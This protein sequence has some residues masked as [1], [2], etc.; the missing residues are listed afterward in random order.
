MNR[1]IAGLETLMTLPG[2]GIPELLFMVPLAI[3]ILTFWIVVVA[4]IL[5]IVGYKPSV[6]TVNVSDLAL[7]YL[8]DAVRTIGRFAIAP[9]GVILLFVLLN[10]NANWNWQSLSIFDQ[11]YDILRPP[12]ERANI[13]TT[14]LNVTAMPVS[15]STANRPAWTQQSEETTPE[16]K[17]VVLSSRLWSTPLEADNEL[18]VKVTQMLRA[19]FDQRHHSWLDPKA[20][21]CLS[22]SRI[23]E[24][25]VKDRY[26]EGVE[27]DFG[28]FSSPMNRLW[29]Q[30]EISPIVRTELYEDWRQAVV[31]NRVFALGAGLSFA[32]MGFSALGMFAALHGLTR[33]RRLQFFGALAG[34]TAV[35]LWCGTFL[36]LTALL[37]K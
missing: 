31:Q 17:R 8:R 18:R 36:S 24:V 34:I 13:T 33:S 28:T 25:A 19:D 11:G 35:L 23:V 4:V 5:R 7:P 20:L 15:N 32:T 27:Q 6:A 16:M 26:L 37:M 21:R 30:V 12:A 1:D 9:T 29:W 2:I 22:E 10:Q 14:A 3:V